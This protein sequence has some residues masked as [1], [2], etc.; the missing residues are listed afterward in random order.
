[1]VDVNINA[2]VLIDES[3][4]YTQAQIGR[5]QSLFKGSNLNRISDKIA[6]K[7]KLFLDDHWPEIN[8]IPLSP[9]TLKLKPG[10][11]QGSFG[12]DTG[13]VKASTYGDY[14]HNEGQVKIGFNMPDYT[15]FLHNR[16]LKEG[17]PGGVLPPASDYEAAT[18]EIL[19][20][21]IDAALQ[22]VVDG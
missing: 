5:L 15:I 16:L 14:V 8:K 19:K 17:I 6:K 20:G 22:E 10:R 13:K 4:E 7:H 11:Q 9:A 1:M 18:I 21:E 12:V 3:L 2:E